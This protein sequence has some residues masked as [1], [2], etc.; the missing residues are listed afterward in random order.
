MSD[1]IAIDVQGIAQ[2]QRLLHDLPP[3]V[4]DDVVDD[5]S[6]YLINV[7]HAYP[8]YKYVSRRQAYGRTFVSD[9]QRRWFFAS[10]ADGSLQ[11]PY[12]RTQNLSRGWKQVGRGAQSII[13]NETP[14]AA[15]MMG[16][17]EQ[18]R[19]AALIGWRTLEQTLDE[20]ADRITEVA[21]AAAKKAVRKAGG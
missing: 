13:A 11:I 17:S 19:H 8:P 2:L 5:V 6:R 1:F 7:L 15:L 16:D 14:Y 3:L 4:R 12:R 9:K 21:E 18:T 10:L 20:R